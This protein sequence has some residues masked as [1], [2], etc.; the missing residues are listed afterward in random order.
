VNR[1]C[2]RPPG[3][4]LPPLKA[5]MISCAIWINV[6]PAAGSCGNTSDSSLA[7]QAVLKCPAIL[8]GHVIPTREGFVFVVAALS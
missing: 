3:L 6:A 2:G 5:S 8:F 4:V 1:P 7:A